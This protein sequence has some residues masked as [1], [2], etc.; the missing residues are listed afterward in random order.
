MGEVKQKQKPWKQEEPK[1]KNHGKKLELG[2][3][4]LKTL[5]GGSS[6]LNAIYLEP[7]YGTSVVGP[8][9][10]I[11]FCTNTAMCTDVGTSCI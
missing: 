3:E 7:T 10:S 5:N 9:H 8:R 11:E 6:T 2:K 1:M 4:T